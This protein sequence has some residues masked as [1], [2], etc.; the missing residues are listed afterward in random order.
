VEATQ[1]ESR[2]AKPGELRTSEPHTPL[3]DAGKSR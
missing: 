3:R 2:V 1:Q